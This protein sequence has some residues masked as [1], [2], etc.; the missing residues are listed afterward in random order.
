MLQALNHSRPPS[1]R[2]HVS[3]HPVIESAT[4]T[5]N[6]GVTQPLNN[7]NNT[8]NHQT[9]SSTSSN[10]H[11]LNN[12]HRNHTTSTTAQ[13][14]QVQV[15]EVYAAPGSPESSQSVS[16]VLSNSRINSN[17]PAGVPNISNNNQRS[18]AGHISPEI[19]GVGQ[20][21]SIVPVVS[22]HHHSWCCHC[23]VKGWS[24]YSRTVL[25]VITSVSHP[26]WEPKQGL[27]QWRACTWSPN[28]E[29]NVLKQNWSP[30]AIPISCQIW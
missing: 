27:L 22:S 14:E 6:A 8:A 13:N 21:I 29:S 26:C 1:Y 30:R 18:P 20:D 25:N 24:S 5:T 3:D 17:N 9:L 15:A 28:K 12:N 16:V 19:V 2:S 10:N 7:N 4:G 11:N 23:W